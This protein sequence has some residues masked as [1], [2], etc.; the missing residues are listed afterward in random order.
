MSDS[1]SSKPTEDHQKETN[2]STTP[3]EPEGQS[4]ATVFG[5]IDMSYH[6]VHADLYWAVN[7]MLAQQSELLYW[8]HEMEY[9]F[10]DPQSAMIENL[11]T[12]WRDS[13]T[14]V[15]LVVSQ[16]ASV[17]FSCDSTAMSLSDK[18]Y[19]VVKRFAVKQFEVRDSMYWGSYQITPDKHEVS[20]QEH[21]ELLDKI[22]TSITRTEKLAEFAQERL[23]TVLES[24]FRLI[25]G[26]IVMMA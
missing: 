17:D 26:T 20:P 1:Q 11:S 22:Q 12:L 25:D 8:A 5:A 3:K 10:D 9:Y 19:C 24:S 18:I 2:S 14:D 16:F 21:Q 15:G 6:K 4:T 13:F 7:E 23:V